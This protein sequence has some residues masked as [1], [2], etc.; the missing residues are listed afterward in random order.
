[1]IFVQTIFF[2]KISVGGADLAH[3]PVH[4]R[5]PADPTSKKKLGKSEYRILN[6]E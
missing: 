5:P 3:P 2:L 1:M 4:P 6:K